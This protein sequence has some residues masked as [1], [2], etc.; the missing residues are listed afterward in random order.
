MA[1]RFKWQVVQFSAIG[2][3]NAAVDILSLNLLLIIWPTTDAT[4]LLLFNTISYT[5]A[6]IN[7]YIWN[8]KYTFKHHAFFSKR[9][10]LLF[11]GQAIIALG[12]S[13]LVFLG[14]FELL[15]FQSL[16]DIPIFVI[17]N[18]SKGAAMFLSSTASF[19]LMKFIVFTK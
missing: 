12:I 15:E 18:I 4:I 9:E 10:L 7:S 17:Q 3:S 1:K 14:I 19:I 13:N 11:I 6:I 2:I 16:I 5:L 8:T